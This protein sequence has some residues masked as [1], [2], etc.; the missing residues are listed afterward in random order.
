MLHQNL[1]VS[2]IQLLLK[3]EDHFLHFRSLVRFLVF[4]FFQFTNFLVQDLDFTIFLAQSLFQPLDLTPFLFLLSFLRLRT[5]TRDALGQRLNSRHSFLSDL[6]TAESLHQSLINLRQ[7]CQPLFILDQFHVR[8]FK[9]TRQMIFFLIPY[10]LFV[11]YFLPGIKKVF[12]KC[13]NL[14]CPEADIDPR[15]LLV[16]YFKYNSRF[17]YFNCRPF[18]KIIK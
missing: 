2:C 15:L 5:L 7:V 14:L 3:I 17:D 13:K 8:N 1:V 4:V 9:F 10:R 6:I 16:H 12:L 11:R 18:E